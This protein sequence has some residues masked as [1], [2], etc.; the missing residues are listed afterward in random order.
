MSEFDELLKKIALAT[1]F[2]K[3]SNITPGLIEYK[4][5][6]QG[7]VEAHTEGRSIELDFLTA[8]IIRD[9]IKKVAKDLG[10]KYIDTYFDLMKEIIPLIDK[11]EEKI[12]EPDKSDIDSIKKFNDLFKDLGL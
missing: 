4:I 1:F 6:T 2:D 11:F 8:I 12:I 5:D 7:V 10:E 3:L 9:R